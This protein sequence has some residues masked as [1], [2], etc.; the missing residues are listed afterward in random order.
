[1]FERPSM[2]R[3]AM[4]KEILIHQET[5]Q[6]DDSVDVGGHAKVLLVVAWG[7]GQRKKKQQKRF[8]GCRTRRAKGQALS[9]NPLHPN[10]VSLPPRLRRTCEGVAEAVVVVHHRGHAVKPAMKG[11]EKEVMAKE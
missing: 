8:Q 3:K 1:M 7:Q 5:H 2:Q 11:S 9:L 10:P 4:Q 6:V